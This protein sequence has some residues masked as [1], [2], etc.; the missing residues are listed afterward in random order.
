VLFVVNISKP[1]LSNKC[2][3]DFINYK[4]QSSQSAQK[5]DSG[6]NMWV[7]ENIWMAVFAGY[8]ISQS[9]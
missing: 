4:S 3:C 5:E 6:G 2:E 1:P 9:A 8:P 7:C